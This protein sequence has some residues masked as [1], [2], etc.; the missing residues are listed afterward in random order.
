MNKIPRIILTSF[1]LLIPL[2][3]CML[4][5]DSYLIKLWILEFGAAV[6]FIYY[7]KQLLWEKCEIQ[8][9][10]VVSL[11]LTG[12]LLINVLSW[13]LIPTPYKYPA[14]LTLIA[15]IFY[16]LLCYFVSQYMRKNRVIIPLWLI[17]TAGISIYSICQFLHSARVIGTLGNENFL[18]SHIGISIPVCVGF[19]LM[20]KSRPGRVGLAVLIMLFLVTLYLTHARGGWLGL[21]GSI[22]SLAIIGLCPKGRRLI[23]AIFLILLVIGLTLTPW[24]VRFVIT[25]FEGDVRPAI[26]GGTIGMIA[27]KPWL[28]FGKGAYF[29]FYP[30]YRIQE[31]WF[32][33]SPTDL[34]IHAHNE[35]LQILAETGVIGL[36]IFL[37]FIYTVLRFSIKEIDAARGREKYTLLGLVC[38]IIGLLVH[39]LVCNNLQMPSSAVFLWYMLGLVI[40]YLPYRT[41]TVSP[42][43]LARQKSGIRLNG[44]YRYGIFL[45]TTLLMVIIIIQ[46][47]TRPLVSQYLFK[48][49]WQYRDS[50]K[51]EMAIQEYKKAINWHNWDVEMHYRMA[52]AYTMARQNDEAIKKYN[53]VIKLA[54]LYGSVH[55]NMG[56]IYMKMD[57]Y[58]QAV[59]SFLLSL[60]INEGDLITQ[61][62]LSRIRKRYAAR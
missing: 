2:A 11:L 47:A 59:R 45:A 49:G 28:G 34:T 27:E 29:I 37:L 39:N 43:L 53:D 46:T 22:S 31:Y 15:L 38:G 50:E 6:L 14:L 23:I 20:T 55:R 18:A 3:R 58:T 5:F 17:T 8:I 62:N 24:G 16:I 1:I 54:P 30:R 51:W 52:Y 33:R 10:P 25:Q 40:A 60:R 13:I 4:F 9:N 57:R 44:V 42:A 41:W 19:F 21:F 48:K 32:T 61:V 35:F 7:C 26:W 12:Y 36:V 56:I